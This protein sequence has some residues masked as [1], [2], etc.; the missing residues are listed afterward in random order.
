MQLRASPPTAQME[1]QGLSQAELNG[2]RVNLLSWQADVER[3]R[4]KLVASDRV[5]GVRAV[6]LK[7]DVIGQ[8]CVTEQD[9]IARVDGRWRLHPDG[10]PCTRGLTEDDL[11]RLERHLYSTACKN[12]D[13]DRMVARA[14]L[15]LMVRLMGG[16]RLLS[17][18]MSF[19]LCNIKESDDFPD[20]DKLPTKVMMIEQPVDG[21]G[22]RRCFQM[23]PYRWGPLA[24][25]MDAVHDLVVATS[26]SFEHWP[27]A[28]DRDWDALRIRVESEYLLPATKEDLTQAFDMLRLE[29]ILASAMLA[30]G[31]WPTPSACAVVQATSDMLHVVG[32]ETVAAAGLAASFSHHRC[33][34]EQHFLAARTALQVVK[35]HLELIRTCT[36]RVLFASGAK[37]SE[38]GEGW[39]LNKNKI[40]TLD[41]IA[42][43]DVTK[44]NEVRAKAFGDDALGCSR[45]RSLVRTMLR[46]AGRV[47]DVDQIA[48]P[49][50][51]RAASVKALSAVQLLYRL[52][53]AE[54]NHEL[55]A[56]AVAQLARG[57]G[58]YPEM[59]DS[60]QAALLQVAVQARDSAHLLTEV[61][62]AISNVRAAASSRTS[63]GG[64]EHPAGDISRE[65][66]MRQCRGC[67]ESKAEG[68]FD[69]DQWVRRRK[70]WCKSCQPASNAASK[71]DGEAEKESVDALIQEAEAEQMRVAA[72]LTRRNSEELKDSDCKVCFE[73]IAEAEQCCFP[74][75]ARHWI[76]RG[77]LPDLLATMRS[78]AQGERTL[79]CP[80]CR[81]GVADLDAFVRRFSLVDVSRSS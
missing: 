80:M 36:G 35:G 57:V 12:N 3:W 68:E 28:Q 9:C 63:Q 14:A 69:P 51:Q 45:L 43:A 58:A 78:N 54:R 20:A 39:P 34:A 26:T 30:V 56:A 60:A 65:R 31:L 70:R 21:S 15:L 33:G 76:C 10:T 74:C 81:T 73:P 38:Y 16:D 72:E 79:M 48:E 29:T 32:M 42:P 4:V 18:V 41:A 27:A 75:D 25:A 47:M 7:P 62:Q 55:M 2:R 8:P 46:E 40:V 59:S 66:S 50:D 6:N 52:P 37:M 1:L 13:L 64:I 44:F 22:R 11:K 77:C 67:G 24:C 49:T 5:L 17:D 71:Y 61:R 19:R 53:A 23:L